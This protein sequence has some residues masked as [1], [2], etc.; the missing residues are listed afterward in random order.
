MFGAQT[1]IKKLDQQIQESSARLLNV[2][3]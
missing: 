1:W 2:E 3:R